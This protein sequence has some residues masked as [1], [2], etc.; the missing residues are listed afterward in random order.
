MRWQEYKGADMKV[1]DILA[2]KSRVIHSIAP[3]A[4]LLEAAKRLTDNQIGALICTDTAGVIVGMLSERSLAQAMARFGAKAVERQVAEVMNR[5]V[6]ACAV[7]DNVD[8]LLMIM[9][10][11]RCRHLPVVRDGEIAGLVSIGDLV[12]ARIGSS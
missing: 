3:T 9:T 11:T 6:I 2:G 7:D 5:D 8:V 1:E 4:S 12:K 10:E